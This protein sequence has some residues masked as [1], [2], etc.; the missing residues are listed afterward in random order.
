M[1][2]TN[3]LPRV[4]VNPKLYRRQG[5]EAASRSNI[6]DESK[7]HKCPPIEVLKEKH[8]INSENASFPDVPWSSQNHQQSNNSTE[9]INSP[10]SPAECLSPACA[11][12][13][14]ACSHDHDYLSN[15]KLIAGCY[16]NNN[17][18]EMHLS[19]EKNP[20]FLRPWLENK[21]IIRV[22]IPP[23]PPTQSSPR[24]VG[25][26]LG[27]WHYRRVVKPQ[28]DQTAGITEELNRVRQ[29]SFLN[30]NDTCIFKSTNKTAQPLRKAR[31][32]KKSKATSDEKENIEKE[33]LQSSSSS[34]STSTTNS[35]ASK[36]FSIASPSS[37]ELN[38]FDI[39]TDK[40]TVEWQNLVKSYCTKSRETSEKLSNVDFKQPNGHST[41]FKNENNLPI[42]RPSVTPCP[43]GLTRFNKFNNEDEDSE[44]TKNDSAYFSLNSSF[45]SVQPNNSSGTPAFHLN[46]SAGVR[47]RPSTG[48]TSLS[49]A[50]PPSGGKRVA[51]ESLSS[52]SSGSSS[53]DD[54]LCSSLSS[55]HLEHLDVSFCENKN[56]VQSP[57][58]L[59]ADMNK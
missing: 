18:S 24:D 14:N 34:R 16:D 9:S 1:S 10:L 17:A 35:E 29:K 36:L 46:T 38:D 26:D 33:Q 13:A 15:D 51:A 6:S 57:Q 19:N 12:M 31:S 45:C 52:T 40:L 8:L 53:D 3:V 49:S 54:S 43:P 48:H 58:D 20:E 11:A 55:H 32:K 50:R 39:A 42:P 59:L 4:L 7:R 25:K 47:S 23:K 22:P 37:Q 44:P 28:V 2:G 27:P 41:P 56:S 21:A 30:E 5:V